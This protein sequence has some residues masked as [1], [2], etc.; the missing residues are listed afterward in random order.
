MSGV[1]TIY[2]QEAEKYYS[3]VKS[4]ESS[5]VVLTETSHN[6]Y[7]RI[8]S[9]YGIPGFFLAMWFLWKIIRIERS[10]LKFAHDPFLKG[11]GLGS[12]GLFV[13]YIL[14]T[15][16]HNAGFFGGDNFFWYIVGILLA[17]Y[18]IVSREKDRIQ[19]L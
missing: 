11:I 7:L 12:I 5:E 9:Y 19:E 8:F 1:N 17:A 4:L 14:N 10:L 18:N 13:G 2:I 16:F 15:S 6:H 3:K